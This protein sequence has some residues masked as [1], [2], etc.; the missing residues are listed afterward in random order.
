MG[1]ASHFHSCCPS[2]FG[3]HS[4]DAAFL[5]ERLL[6]FLRD[7][8][9]FYISYATSNASTGRLDLLFT[10]A[11]EICASS[12]DPKLPEGK[13]DMTSSPNYGRFP[14]QNNWP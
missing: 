1:S 14:N 11:Q 5:K 6:P 9:A 2:P 8:A 12:I 13:V 3:S 7:V 10:C 4:Q